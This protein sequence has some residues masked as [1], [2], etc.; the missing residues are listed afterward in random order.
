MDRRGFYYRGG[1]TYIAGHLLDRRSQWKRNKGYLLRAGT[2]KD[3]S[4]VV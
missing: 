3:G 4:A 1:I 2:S